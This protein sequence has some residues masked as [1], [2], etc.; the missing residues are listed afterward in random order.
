MELVGADEQNAGFLGHTPSFA[1]TGP[2]FSG[3][4]ELLGWDASAAKGLYDYKNPPPM[5]TSVAAASASQSGPGGNASAIPVPTALNTGLTGLV[6]LVLVGT[7]RRARRAI[8]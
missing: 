7:Y 3:D 5:Q 8:R 2:G 1:L 4:A 6:A